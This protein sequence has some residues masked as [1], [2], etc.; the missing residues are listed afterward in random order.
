VKKKYTQLVPQNGVIP[1]VP[2]E[3]H[4]E[5]L[6]VTLIQWCEEE[7]LEVPTSRTECPSFPL[8]PVFAIDAAPNDFEQLSRPESPL[9]DLLFGQTNSYCIDAAKIDNAIAHM[10]C[11]V[12]SGARKGNCPKCELSLWLVYLVIPLT[13]AFL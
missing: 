9:T 12:D 10:V 5:M 8:M 11:Y 13:S 4:L 6:S 2:L 3:C 1:L 7:R